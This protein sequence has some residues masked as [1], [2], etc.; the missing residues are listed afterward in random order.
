MLQYPGMTPDLPS[1]SIRVLGAREVDP[2]P[3]RR[4]LSNTSYAGSTL[5][6]YRWRGWGACML[7][8]E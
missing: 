1:V 7:S 3:V 6:R 2:D 8:V 4:T 5:V